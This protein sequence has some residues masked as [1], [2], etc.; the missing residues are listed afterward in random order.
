MLPEVTTT[1]FSYGTVASGTSGCELNQ[2]QDKMSKM[3]IWA[4]LLTWCVQP[5]AVSRLIYIAISTAPP[6]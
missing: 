4:W 5:Q 1:E 3:K 2:K 6:V